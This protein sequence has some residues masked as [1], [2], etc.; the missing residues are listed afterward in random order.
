[1][2]KEALTI[3]GFW[4][5]ITRLIKWS[6]ILLWPGVIIYGCGMAVGSN[7]DKWSEGAKTTVTIISLVISVPVY[8]VYRRAQQNQE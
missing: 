6:L 1:M 8:L 4:W 3:Y 2:V 5:G 7:P